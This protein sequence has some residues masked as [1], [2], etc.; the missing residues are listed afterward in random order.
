MIIYKTVNLIT[1]K[2]YIGKDAAN[3]NSYLGSGKALKNAIRKYGVQNF[4]KEIIEECADLTHMSAREAHWIS[5]SNAVNDPMSYNLVPGGEGGDR[6]KFIDYAAVDRTNY[7]MTG[8]KAWFE[9]LSEVQRSAWHAKQGL[10]RCKGWYVSKVDNTD[11]I[12]VLNI[13]KWCRENNID[14]GMP[15]KMNDPADSCYQRAAKG[16]RIRRADMPILP[17]YVKY[18]RQGYP[19]VACRGKSWKMIDGKRIWIN[20]EEKA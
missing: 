6:S 20:K 8:T 18:I 14:I 9:A 19:N 2:W 7:K 17:V 3:L 12:Y 1:G 10:A 4:K 13:A 16:W 11:E 5:I 15:T